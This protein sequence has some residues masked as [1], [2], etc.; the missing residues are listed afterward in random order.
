MERAWCADTLTFALHRGGQCINGKVTVQ[1]SH[2]VMDIT[3]P[4]TLALW[5]GWLLS[6]ITEESRRLLAG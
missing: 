1:D 3:L 4:W 2:I 5:K 6:V